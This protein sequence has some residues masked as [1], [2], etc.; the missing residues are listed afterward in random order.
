MIKLESKASESSPAI[1]SLRAKSQEELLES[2]INVQQYD[3][4]LYYLESSLFNNAPT[5][6]CP[7]AFVI[8][9]LFTLATLGEYYNADLIRKEFDK[10]LSSQP[11][12]IRAIN[13]LKRLMCIVQQSC[14]KGDQTFHRTEYNIEDVNYTKFQL[15]RALELIIRTDKRDLRPRILRK[16]Y[17]EKKEPEPEAD[18]FTNTQPSDNEKVNSTDW[19]PQK[20]LLE[21]QFQMVKGPGADSDDE[22]ESEGENILDRKS[23]MVLKNERF[24]IALQ[25]DSFWAAVSWAL[26]CSTSRDKVRL[27]A[28]KVWR[29]ILNILID[30]ATIDLE[31]FISAKK[32]NIDGADGM[33]AMFTETL[34]YKLLI[35]VGRYNPMD[36]LLDVI[37]PKVEQTKN[38]RDKKVGPIFANELTTARSVH[39]VDFLF[40]RPNDERISM[41][42]MLLRKKLYFLT[43]RA[44]NDANPDDCFKE[45]RF[46]S[47]KLA[48]YLTQ[49]LVDLSYGDFKKFFILQESE[50]SETWK[51]DTILDVLF[52]WFVQINGYVFDTPTLD[53]LEDSDPEFIRS[54]L[55]NVFYEKE[56]YKK[57]TEADSLLKHMQTD[58]SKLN[59]SLYF[60]LNLWLKFSNFLSTEKEQKIKEI[61]RWCE[62]GE[63]KRRAALQHAKP[64]DKNVHKDLFSLVQAV[65]AQFNMK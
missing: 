61:V 59:F 21:Q 17:K 47:W 15:I 55:C 1:R 23:Y 64:K 22:S 44:A 14:G 35:M 40:Q 7:S 26:E 10:P 52:D 49:K 53:F 6:N 3:K 43:Y 30:I 37:F 32:S 2:F 34:A 60:L 5:L 28:W 36:N 11:L 45:S 31:D 56:F 8:N 41:E 4:L 63:S 9:C 54:F 16:D 48:R 20:K 24:D 19:S 12:H 33:P 25:N 42:S 38:K 18:E 46:S 57:H 39:L 62:T 27:E 51:L 58:F 50:L 65:K 29:P 13:I